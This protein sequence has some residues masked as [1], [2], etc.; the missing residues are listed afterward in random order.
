MGHR[1]MFTFSRETDPA[2]GVLKPPA[3]PVAHWA[4]LL[5][6]R[7]GSRPLHQPASRREGMAFNLA[8]SALRAMKNWVLVFFMIHR[9]ISS[10]TNEVNY[11]R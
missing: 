11:A 1:P 4:Q 7:D 6:L 9:M 10:S 5:P 8:R 3:R 2:L